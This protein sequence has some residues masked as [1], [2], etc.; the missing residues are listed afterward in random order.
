MIEQWQYFAS[1]SSGYSEINLLLSFANTNYYL[2]CESTNSDASIRMFSCG[3]NSRTENSFKMKA[4]QTDSGGWNEYTS[5]FV[6]FAI[7][8]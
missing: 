8:Y 5:S 1:K 7:G 3:I 6:T 4:I 2:G